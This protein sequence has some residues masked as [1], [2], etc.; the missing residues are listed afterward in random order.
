VC[1]RSLRFTHDLPPRRW[2][3][4]NSV[5]SRASFSR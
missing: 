5:R 1:G 4:R 2:R 3:V